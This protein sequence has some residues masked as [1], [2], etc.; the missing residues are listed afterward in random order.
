MS[1]LE[2]QQNALLGFVLERDRGH[3]QRDRE[4]PP[5]PAV[6]HGRQDKRARE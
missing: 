1:F 2:K 4:E 5:D 3:R 6:T